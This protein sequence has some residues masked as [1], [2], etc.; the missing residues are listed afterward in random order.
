MKR[1]QLYYAFIAGG[2]LL[3]TIVAVVNYWP[4]SEVPLDPPQVVA[5][6]FNDSSAA[7]EK[8]RAARDFIRHGETAR[9][10]IRA[11][12]EQHSSLEP[13]VV[14]P[15]VQ[16]TGKTRDYRSMPTLL[17]LLEHPDPAVRGAAGTAVQKILGADFG[18]RANAPEAERAK[19]IKE[20][21]HDY[22][23]AGPRLREFYNN[24]GH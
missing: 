21:R 18:F 12:L 23:V 16:A 5:Q 4:S 15:L 20:M 13:E 7:E 3:M 9:I 14:A 1:E 24:Q 17:D 8:V 6:R 2:L 10:E 19:L 22:E 11:A